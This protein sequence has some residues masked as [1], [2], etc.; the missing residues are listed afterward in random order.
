MVFAVTINAQVGRRRGVLTAAALQQVARHQRD[1]LWRKI[2]TVLRPEVM[3]HAP[4]S[5]PHKVLLK[6]GVLGGLAENVFHKSSDRRQA[7]HTTT[8][9]VSPLTHCIHDTILVLGVVKN[10][11]IFSTYAHRSDLGVHTSRVSS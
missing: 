6:R 10:V 3:A 9:L 1:K 5:K 4:Y 8:S 7:I 2:L 11:F